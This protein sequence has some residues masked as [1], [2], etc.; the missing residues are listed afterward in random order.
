MNKQTGTAIYILEYYSAIE[1]NELPRDR[2]MRNLKCILL[3]ERSQPE[4]ATY[5]IC[6]QLYDILEKAKP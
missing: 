3:S 4:K 2:D 5:C 6:L 1:I